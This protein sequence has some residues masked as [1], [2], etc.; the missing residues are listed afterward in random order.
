MPI[1]LRS[2]LS[3]PFQALLWS[4]GGF[5]SPRWRAYERWSLP[6]A[7]DELA[8]RRLY[9]AMALRSLGH[10]GAQEA[11]ALAQADLARLRALQNV[12]PGMRGPAFPD[13]GVVVP[14]EDRLPCWASTRGRPSW[15]VRLFMWLIRRGWLDATKS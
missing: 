3:E 14:D 10:P 5:Q 11:Y 12:P 2:Q 13:V 4:E 6:N 1:G 7:Q 15:R 8:Y 9:E